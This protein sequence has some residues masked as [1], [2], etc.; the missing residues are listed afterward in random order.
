[1]V[2]ATTTRVLRRPPGCVLDTTVTVCDGPGPGRRNAFHQERIT[3]GSA[4]WN[5]VTIPEPTVS[6]AHCV[7]EYRSEGLAIRDL[8]SRNG[9][10]VGGMR[11]REAFLP[12]VARI[13]LGRATLEVR[14][15]VAG[16]DGAEADGL[17][18]IVAKSRSM[19]LIVRVLRRVAASD[20]PVVLEGEPGT[21]KR[22]IARTLHDIGPRVACPFIVVDGRLVAQGAAELEASL[23]SGGT[24]CL[25]HV[26]VLSP[27]LQRRLLH[28]IERDHSPGRPRYVV[29]SE[30]PLEQ[31]VTQERFRR[32]LFYCLDVVRLRV[33]PL[34]ERPEDLR[35]LVEQFLALAASTESVKF[36][37]DDDLV[38]RLCRARWPG[39]VSE[40]RSAVARAV[41]LGDPRSL[42]AS[43]ALAPG[44]P[45]AL[46]GP[47]GHRSNGSDPR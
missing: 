15:T 24:L 34:R 4:S 2:T 25:E 5:D 19:R 35:P 31:A 21:G 26:V 8:D 44:P 27:E 11:V 42:L 10:F 47:T 40:L 6:R 46:A 18:R 29:T 43:W 32:D 17:G 36:T 13:A 20:V 41:A 22:L 1:M 16:R 30:E 45:A 7:L 9:T 37:V 33:A 23:A 14:S 38:E 39:N 3:I 28:L 12:P